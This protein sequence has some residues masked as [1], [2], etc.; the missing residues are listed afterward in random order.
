VSWLSATAEALRALPATLTAN[1]DAAGD[2]DPSSALS[3][4]SANSAPFT[5]AHSSAGGAGSGALRV[6]VVLIVFSKA[7]PGAMFL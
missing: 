4:R 7:S 6:P 2:D 1:A 3:K 5:R